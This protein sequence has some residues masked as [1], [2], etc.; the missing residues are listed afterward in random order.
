MHRTFSTSD[1][2]HTSC[3]SSG[4]GSVFA[5]TT[6]KGPPTCQ[7]PCFLSL[8]TAAAAAS[9][10]AGAGALLIIRKATSRK[11]FPRLSTKFSLA[12]CESGLLLGS[13]DSSSSR[14]NASCARG[15]P[16]RAEAA[17]EAAASLGR[18]GDQPRSA[19]WAAAAKAP[20]GTCWCVRRVRA[21]G[22]RPTDHKLGI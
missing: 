5:R 6:Y 12:P 11:D 13:S 19:R 14:D 9:A 22:P 10:A 18:A 17:A 16:R 8:S 20:K 3:G 2:A 21:N 7:K 1:G 15:R 4:S